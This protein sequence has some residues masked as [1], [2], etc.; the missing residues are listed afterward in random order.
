MAA[1]TED[2]LRVAGAELA[3]GERLVWADRPDPKARTRRS[4]PRLAFG[5][6]V[7]LIA[8]AWSVQAMATHG[9]LALTGLVFVAIGILITTLP[10]WRRRDG[11]T[12]YAITDR[13][14]M[15]IRDGANRR[16][17]SF[18]PDD[19]ETL[20]RRERPDGSGDVIFARETLVPDRVRGNRAG[21]PY[22]GF[23]RRAI[24]FF[25]IAD[26]QRVEAA[27]RALRDAAR[28]DER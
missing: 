2:P 10:L 14:L 4:W 26:V 8:G 1:D 13:R 12:V 21:P 6:V 28:R 23:R 16:V 3:S 11:Q 5:A 22:Q 27:V 15:I 25:G 7:T 18:Q 24:G 17:R 20:E 9:G 19:I